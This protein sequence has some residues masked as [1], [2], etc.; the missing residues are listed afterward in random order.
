VL[1]VFGGCGKGT[2][3]NI[4]LEKY[5]YNQFEIKFKI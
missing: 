4:L 1:G 2:Q 5:L 3:S